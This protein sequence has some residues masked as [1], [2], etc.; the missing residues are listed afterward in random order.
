MPIVILLAGV[1]ICAIVCDSS[2]AEEDRMDCYSYDFL[3]TVGQV[4]FKSFHSIQVYVL[5]EL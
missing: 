3:A 5:C 2:E 4:G 1:A